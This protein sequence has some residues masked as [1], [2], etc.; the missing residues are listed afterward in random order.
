MK[1]DSWKIRVSGYGTFDFHGTEEEAEAMRVHKAR[2]EDG[3]G[4]KW[5]TTNQTPVD[6][7]TAEMAA[8]WDQHRGVPFKLLQKLKAARAA[9]AM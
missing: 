4:L 1:R 9:Q 2:W 5:R 3:S 6:Q 7:I 8:L